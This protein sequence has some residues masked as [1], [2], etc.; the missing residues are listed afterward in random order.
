M[1]TAVAL[2]LLVLS[3]NVSARH[4]HFGP[5]AAATGVDLADALFQSMGSTSNIAAC[6]KIINL[7]S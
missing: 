2:L 1:V 3:G 6:I 5:L 4:T 7:L